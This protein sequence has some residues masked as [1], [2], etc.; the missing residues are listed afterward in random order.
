[1][2]NNTFSIHFYIKKEKLNKNGLAPI[3]AKVKINGMK[4]EFS[5]TRTV[6]PH[7]WMADK[8]QVRSSDANLKQINEHLESFKT[9]LYATYSKLLRNDVELTTEAFKTA[10]AGKKDDRSV[11]SFIELIKEHNLDYEKLV[12]IKYTPGGYKCYKTTLKYVTEFT[13]FK[14]GRRDIR[15]EEVNFK[16]CEGF[17][18]WLTSCKNCKINGANKQIQRIKK[19]L[20]FSI[21]LG[22]INANPMH[23]YPLK[24]RIQER[25]A[26]NDIELKTMIELSLQRDTLKEVKD[27]FLFQCYTGLSY[28]DVCRLSK[29]HLVEGR[30]GVL[31]IKMKRAKTNVS[32]SIPLLEPAR[33]LLDKYSNSLSKKSTLLPV[34]SNQKMNENLKLIQKLAGLPKNLT[35]HLARHTF[36][37]TITLTN[38]VPIETVSKMLG[39]TSLKTTQIY[40]KVVDTKIQE[41]MKVLAEKLSKNQLS[42]KY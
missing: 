23:T 6:A 1:M 14:Y 32:F 29:E 28:S 12:G 30:D 36:A 3:V 24:F 40:A 16:F 25:I 17:F 11:P 2:A 10:L 19:L 35:S 9:K 34:L 42:G 7:L 5:T 33:K 18:A 26:L 39:H 20:N 4:A 22:Y 27:V 13:T 8:E 37:T 31:W 21:R 15:L 41:D 38:G